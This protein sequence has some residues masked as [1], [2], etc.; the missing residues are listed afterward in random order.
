MGPKGIIFTALFFFFLVLLFLP[1]IFLM[2]GLN[3][4]IPVSL[5]ALFFLFR[6]KDTLCGLP[7]IHF[8]KL[9]PADI[10]PQAIQKLNGRKNRQQQK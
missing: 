6:R 7:R 4:S 1:L 10:S 5:K 9:S 8:K 2:P 3:Q